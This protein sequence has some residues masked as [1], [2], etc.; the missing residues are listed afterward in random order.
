MNKDIHFVSK[1]QYTY[2]VGKN[3]RRIRREQELTQ[4]GLSVAYNFNPGY[5][6]LVEKANVTLTGYSLYKIACVLG[7]E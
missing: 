3:I 6:N 7:V 5:I 4:E 2:I 1:K